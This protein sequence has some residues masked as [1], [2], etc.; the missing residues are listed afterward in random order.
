MAHKGVSFDFV[1]AYAKKGLAEK[2]CEKYILCTSASF[3]ITA[4]GEAMAVSLAECWAHRH[5][6]MLEQWVGSGTNVAFDLAGS[7]ATHIEPARVA[8]IRATGHAGAATRPA[9]FRKVMPRCVAM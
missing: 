6:F 7:L 1:M 2:M 3:S 4:Y 9:G 5:N 8:E